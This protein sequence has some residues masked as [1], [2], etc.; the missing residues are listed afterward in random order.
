LGV[1]LWRTAL[2]LAAMAVAVACPQ[3][4][5]AQ[6]TERLPDL[7]SD[8]PDNTQLQTFAQPDG[9]HLLLRF[10]GYV[11]NAGSGAFE[12]RGSNRLND[13][14]TTVVQRVFRSDG[15]FFDDSSRDPRIIFEPE[16]GHD[17][18]HLKNAA[19]YSLWNE[20]KTAEV[21]PALK[22][23]FCLIDSQRRETNGPSS[24]FYDTG[25][26]NFCGQ[27]QPTLASLFEGVSA[28]WR[29]LYDRTLAFQWV[30]VSDAQ[31]GNYWLRAEIDPDDVVRESNE[32]NAATF[33]TSTSTI[34]GYLANPVAAGTVS[35]T[36][37]TTIPL[38]TT[39]FGT[40]L[41]TRTFRIIVPPRRGTLNVVLGPTFT[42]TS[43]V[44][45][46]RP[47]WVGPDSFTYTVQNSSSAFPHY[48]AAAAV[49]LNV[50]G[51]FPNVAI[52]GAP[53]TLLAGTSARLLAAV[54]AED[55][56][57]TWSVDGIDSGTAE[58]GTVDATGLYVAPATAPPSGSATIR[59]TTASGAFDEV[60]IQVD[61][62]PPAQP[63]PAVTA[64]A[65]IGVEAGSTAAP[66]RQLRALR[67]VRLKTVGRQL[68]V[69][70][71]PSRAGVVR[72]RVRDGA[73]LLGSC[74]VRGT[75]SRTLVC[76]TVLPVGVSPAAVAVVMTLR[77]RGELVEVRRFGLSPQT[78]LLHHP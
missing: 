40:G 56:Y 70:T 26:N 7:V 77:V 36:G 24:A 75:R 50:G 4:A 37:P 67:G 21:A 46:P 65:D 5:S 71:R 57:V 64:A 52:S 54:T 62:P 73:N 38:S 74:R 48:P 23:G 20:A 2:V 13:E 12:M 6:V 35:A 9:N 25:D 58:T 28:G 44:Y 45:T 72:I 42:S 51:V 8:A 33:R 30:D 1:S 69:S 55:P 19:R 61:N 15:S 53:A 66:A 32:V 17:H 43:V 47:G 22:V 60:T 3:A 29:D 78:T 49:T 18:W 68:V 41:G 14:M 76:R 10:N 39:S 59:A 31:P 16:D 11:H 34:P 27:G 63:A